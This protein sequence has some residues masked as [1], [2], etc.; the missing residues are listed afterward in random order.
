MMM[1]GL[2]PEGL[3]LAQSEVTLV[4]LGV[5]LIVLD[6]HLLLVD[7]FAVAVIVNLSGL[8]ILYDLHPVPL[9]GDGV[10]V[11]VVVVVLGSL[12]FLINH[13]L[14]EGQV[15]VG[16]GRDIGEDTGRPVHS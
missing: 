13:L 1:I 15:G 5:V 9:L 12:L 4:P 11:V 8:V 2:L 7:D 3:P 14:V 16:V 6:V 10:P